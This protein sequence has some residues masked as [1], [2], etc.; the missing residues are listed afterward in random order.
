MSAAQTAT[1]V[2]A[3]TAEVI[4]NAVVAITREMKTNLMRTAY[5]SIIYE[6]EDFTV[7][8]FD[9]DGHTISKA[10][11]PACPERVIAGHHADLASGGAY[12]YIDP[13]T[14]RILAGAYG[15]A[16]LAGGG[17]G[18]KLGEDGMKPPSAST[19]VSRTTR[20][21]KPVQPRHPCSSY[22]APCG[23]IRAALANGAAASVSSR[24]SRC[25]PRPCLIRESNASSVRPGACTGAR[26][27]YRMVST[28]SGRTAQSSA[29]PRG[30]STLCAS[31]RATAT[32]SKQVGAAASATR[33]SGRPSRY[34]GTSPRGTSQ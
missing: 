4:R 13:E 3:F 21:S 27:L 32:P 16:G 8:L 2:D 20:L 22:N 5:S 15:G 12:G 9:A 11:A 28:W 34:C 14:G 10:L 19:M 26:L 1:A 30:R 7:G 33:S 31:M 18:A 25:S 24:R 17:W 6:A 29:L 23:R